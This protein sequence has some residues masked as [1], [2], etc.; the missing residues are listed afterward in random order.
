[1]VE[2]SS[3]FLCIWEDTMTVWSEVCRTSL[4]SNRDWTESNSSLE[5]KWIINWDI[6]EAY[7]FDD[8]K[9]IFSLTN[10]VNSLVW[11]VLLEFNWIG[12]SIFEGRVHPSTM[13]TLVGIISW[14]FMWAVDKLLFWEVI[15]SS[16]FNGM[17]TFYGANSWEGPTWT[18]WFLVLWSINKAWFEP[19]NWVGKCSHSLISW[20]RVGFSWWNFQ[21]EHLFV[22]AFVHVWELIQT[23]EETL[24]WGIFSVVGH[25]EL[26]TF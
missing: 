21:T 5:L 15:K 25:D 18:A 22:F 23:H 1:M 11:I 7:G 14:T 24:F 4:D 3:T 26:V 2:V 17:G 9:S 6:N 12:K 19:V 10:L 13:A 20:S 16:S 8:S